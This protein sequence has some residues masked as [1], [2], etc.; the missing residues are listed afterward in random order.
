VIP[1]LLPPLRERRT[2]VPLLVEHFVKKY[3]GGQARSISDAA[4]KVLVDYDWPGN[5]RELEAVVERSLLLAEGAVVEP[6]DL[7]PNVRANI[8]LTR[9][10]LG[11]E[12]PRWAST[13]KRSKSPVEGPRQGA[14][15]RPRA[16][17]LLGLTR[18][19]LQ[20]RLEKIQGGAGEPSGHTKAP[21][22]PEPRPAVLLPHAYLG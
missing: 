20:Y 6:D 15:Q 1:I 4:L 5:V 16:A 2:D 3:G 18:R 10:A 19:T 22:R 14:G 9:G 17:R 12:I 21:S 13:S 7:P 8:A 11:L